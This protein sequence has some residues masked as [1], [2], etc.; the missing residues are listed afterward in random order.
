MLSRY[1]GPLLKGLIMLNYICSF[2]VPRCCTK[3]AAICATSAVVLG[4]LCFPLLAQNCVTD[5][6]NRFC[7][8]VVE[9]NDETNSWDYACFYFN[10]QSDDP[11][12]MC[13]DGSSIIAPSQYGNCVDDGVQSLKAYESECDFECFDPNNPEA[14]WFEASGCSDGTYLFDDDSTSCEGPLPSVRKG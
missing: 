8:Q 7:W 12:D 1:R 2:L 13:F 3:F 11:A 6:G 14:G 4:T 5:C 9:W 10:D